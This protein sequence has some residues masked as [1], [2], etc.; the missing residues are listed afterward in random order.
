MMGSGGLI[1]DWRN[2][3][4]EEAGEGK[5]ELGWVWVAVLMGLGENMRL[6]KDQEERMAFWG[7][8]LEG[9]RERGDRF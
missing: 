9:W 6:R 1:E 5:E 2:D 7:L 8:R 4:V 3:R